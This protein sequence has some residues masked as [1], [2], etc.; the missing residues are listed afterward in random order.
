[1]GVERVSL[2]RIT[3]LVA[4]SAAVG[5]RARRPRRAWSLRPIARAAAARAQLRGGLARP[6]RPLG[7]RSRSGPDAAP[8]RGPRPRPWRRRLEALP[9]LN[10]RALT[11]LLPVLVY[12]LARQ[13]LGTQAGI[14]I[15]FATLLIVFKINRERGVLS[16][17]AAL[18]LVLA[19]FTAA[20]GIA[21]NSDTAFFIRDPI[22]DF[23]TAT[24]LL[25]SLLVRRPLVGLVVHEIWPKCAQS[26]DLQSRLFYLLTLLWA[27][28]TLSIGAARI[29]LLLQ[30]HSPEAYLIWS[31]LVSWSPAFATGT[32]TVLLVARAVQAHTVRSAAPKAA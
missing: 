18:G 5:P 14:G 10:L 25:A 24:V 1:M 13:L 31:R 23:I 7:W 20:A 9:A 2:G 4:G 32:V 12:V 19:A 21:L 6:R 3:A 15:T 16:G 27:A 30:E 29:V 28:Q 26:I 11:N 17:I 22:G 8:E